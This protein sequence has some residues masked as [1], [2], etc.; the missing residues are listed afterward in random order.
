MALRLA[1]EEREKFLKKYKTTLF[2]AYGA[3]QKEY[4]TVPDSLLKNTNELRKYFDLSYRVC[5]DLET[6]TVEKEGLMRVGASRA[7]NLPEMLAL[8]Q[9]LSMR[10]IIFNPS[11]FWAIAVLFAALIGGS[12]TPPRGAR[13]LGNAASRRCEGKSHAADKEAPLP[14]RRPRRPDHSTG[15]QAAALH[16]YR[17]RAARLRHRQE[18]RQCGLHRVH[19]DGPDRPVTFALNG[20]PGASPSF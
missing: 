1:P 8:R 3:I 17:G 9:N 20:G 12:S 13:S 18:N 7:F 11:R 5:A 10:F 2:E 15:W 4:V 16:R 19:V 6:E 14:G